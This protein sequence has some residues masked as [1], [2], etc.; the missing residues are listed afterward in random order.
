VVV[1][2]HHGRVGPLGEDRAFAALLLRQRRR[3]QIGDGSLWAPSP[4]DQLLLQA[5]QVASRR[6]LRLSDLAW[7]IEVARDGR[8]AWPRVLSTAKSLGLISRLSCYLD[9]VGQ[10]HR[11]VFNQPLLPTDVRGRLELGRWGQI[12]FR[13]GAYRFPAGLAMRRLWLDEMPSRV[14]TGD[15]AGA[16]RMLLLPVAAAAKRLRDLAGRPR[17]T[18]G[19]GA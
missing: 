19:S 17:P 5:M 9:Y 6:A 10:V 8:L 4:E 12:A 2:V 16:G 15:L 3:V 18:E 1:D 14:G 7:T 13:D 11:R